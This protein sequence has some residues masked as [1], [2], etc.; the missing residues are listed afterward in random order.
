M[1]SIG[2]S[3]DGPTPYYPDMMIT[4]DPFTQPIELPHYQPIFETREPPLST[5]GGSYD[6][7]IIPGDHYDIGEPSSFPYMETARQ[8][9]HYPRLLTRPED[10]RAF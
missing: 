3:E 1:E 4:D 10:Y 8:S 7:V 6:G 5:C 9:Y 2:D